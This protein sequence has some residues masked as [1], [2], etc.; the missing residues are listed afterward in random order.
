M[1]ERSRAASVLVS[2]GVLAAAAAAPAW[3]VELGFTLGASVG[4]ATFDGTEFDGDGAEDSITGAEFAWYAFIGWRPL[5]WLHFEGGY[6]DFGAGHDHD[7]PQEEFELDGIMVTAVGYIPIRSRYSIPVRAG[8]FSYD[9]VKTD[10]RDKEEQEA[11]ELIL[12]LGVHI[13]IHDNLGVRVEGTYLS[14]V[15]ERGSE[16]PGQADVIGFMVGVTGPF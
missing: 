3:G 14:N 16:L 1:P 10:P 7:D 4:R 9:F 11:S 8:V 13:K 15:G 5:E 12:G 6:M 2:I